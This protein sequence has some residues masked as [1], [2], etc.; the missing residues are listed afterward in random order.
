MTCAF[1]LAVGPF[2]DSQSFIGD[3]ASL[4]LA[5]LE[6]WFLFQRFV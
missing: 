6:A 5:I 1:L 3:G 2:I 4:D